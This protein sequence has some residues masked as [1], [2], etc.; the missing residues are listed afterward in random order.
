MKYF[1]EKVF[2]CFYL[3]KKVNLIKKILQKK[4]FFGV[5]SE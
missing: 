5:P 3:Q 1:L 4:V 2:D